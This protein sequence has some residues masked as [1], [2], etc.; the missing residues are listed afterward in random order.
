MD[1]IWWIIAAGVALPLVLV[2]LAGTCME[3]Y[4]SRRLLSRLA[5]ER[6][7][8]EDQRQEL[9]AGWDELD[10]G[11]DEFESEQ[12]GTHRRRWTTQV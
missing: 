4:R 6:R 2:F 9:A 11:W 7:D 1:I 8:L 12:A 3:T 10:A 5:N